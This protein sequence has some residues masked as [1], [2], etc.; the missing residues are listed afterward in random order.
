MKKY[1]IFVLLSLIF[2]VFTAR[3]QDV[4]HHQRGE[5]LQ[6]YLL[7]SVKFVS[8][9]F[10][11]GVITFSDGGFSRAPVNISTIEQRV[12]FISPEGQYQVLADEDQVRRVSIKGRTFIKS[13]Y[14]YVEIL[15]TDGDVSLG[16]VYRTSFFE[17][18][19]KG[20]SNTRSS[21]ISTRTG[22]CT[23]PTKRTSRN[24]SPTRKRFWKNI[25]P[26]TPSISRISTT[27]V[28][29][30]TRY[31]KPFVSTSGAIFPTSP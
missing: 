12:Y 26:G 1:L 22:R 13:K 14:G 27:S 11:A 3:A 25:S 23:S 31:A 16:A 19:K 5:D 30:T 28:P 20:R 18:E 10:Q 17:T 7:D 24:A 8:P 15:Q 21:P 4:V 6:Q 29:S 2:T 9:E